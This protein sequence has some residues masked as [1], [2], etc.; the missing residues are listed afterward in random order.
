MKE[1]IRTGNDIIDLKLWKLL[2]HTAFVINRTRKKE[3]AIFSLTP[4]KAYVLD[5]LHQSGGSVTIQ[6][7][8]D[9][10]MRRHNSISTLVN[11]MVK[12]GYVVKT[13]DKDDRRQ[14][15]V[16]ITEKGQALFDKFSS[17]TIIDVFSI[18]SENDKIRLEKCL[19]QVR[20]KTYRALGEE[21]RPNIIS[22]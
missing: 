4:E 16:T 14:Y 20:D 22:D 6:K 9:I 3:L 15:N 1:K 21:Y 11:R 17:N 7:I 18:L 2:D 12:Q 10:T 5:I 13:R 8:A 19:R